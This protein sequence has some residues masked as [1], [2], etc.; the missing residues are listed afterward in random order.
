MSFI[1]IDANVFVYAFLKPKRK[2]QPHEIIMKEAAKRIVSRIGAGEEVVSSVVHFSEVCNVLED[3]MPQDEA[4]A[5]EKGLLLS[6]NIHLC[7][8]S[9]EDYINT[10]A[11][12]ERYQIGLND[13]LAYVLMRN[14]EI[15]KIYSFDRDF[16]RFPDIERQ[17]E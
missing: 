4:L 14:A 5:L 6:E 1:Y 2:L 15:A 8:V 9:Q 13:A 7:E 17:T 3:Y 11:F 12:S 10:V 16:D